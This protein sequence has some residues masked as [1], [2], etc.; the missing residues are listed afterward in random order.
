MS[1]FTMTKS[2]IYAQ[3]Q[4]AVYVDLHYFSFFRFKIIRR[5]AGIFF[6]SVDIVRLIVYELI[7]DSLRGAFH[8]GRYVR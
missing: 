4:I 8:L 3:R 7:S 5:F 1:R 2:R 6:L